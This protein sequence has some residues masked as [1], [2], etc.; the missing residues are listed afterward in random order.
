MKYC[1]LICGIKICCKIPY[2]VLHS[3]CTKP[4]EYF[5]E[6]DSQDLIFTFRGVTEIEDDRAAG[7][8]QDEHHYH[9]NADGYSVCHYHLHGE[10][11]YA[12]VYAYNSKPGELFCDYQIGC[13]KRIACTR[14]LVN[15]LGMETF[16][17]HFQRMLIHAS[18][19]NW[20]GMGIL[21]TAPS[22]TGKSTQAELWKLHENAEILNGDR[23]AIGMEHGAWTAWGL[24]IAGTSGI[25]RNASIPVSAVVVLGQAAEN[26]IRRLMPGEALRRIYP[27]LTI[28]RWDPDFV[29]KALELSLDLLESVPVYLLECLPNQEAVQVLKQTLMEEGALQ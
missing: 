24:P 1:F 22:G 12:K 6:S 11:P 26:R 25:Y 3:E 27:E 13:E 10:R 17:L 14:D 5:E 8:W 18:L 20:Q 16:L 9:E 19:I 28:H 15:L 21:F 4:F 7:I 23:A 2:Q 29:N